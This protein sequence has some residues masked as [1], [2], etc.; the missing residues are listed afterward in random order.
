M[1]IK[2]CVETRGASGWKPKLYPSV[3]DICT[4]AVHL[5][6]KN[7]EMCFSYGGPIIHKPNSSTDQA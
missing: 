6:A 5:P 2:G 4:V 7:S 3:D 1:H